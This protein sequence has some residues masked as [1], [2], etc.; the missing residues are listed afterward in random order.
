MKQSKLRLV[1]S[2]HPATSREWDLMSLLPR[3]GWSR[4]DHGS[5]ALL[6]DIKDRTW[7]TV[8]QPGVLLLPLPGTDCD[9][10][11]K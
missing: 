11:G 2:S 8:W 6:G 7:G 3:V 4:L 5:S 9:H 1:Q 10:Q